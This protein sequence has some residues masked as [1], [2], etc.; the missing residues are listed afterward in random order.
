MPISGSRRRLMPRWKTL[1]AK[2]MRRSPTDAELYLWKF[3]QLRPYG[4]KWRRQAPLFGYIPDFYCAAAAMI[5]ECDGPIHE[6]QR[7]RI[8]DANLEA[9]GLLT[10]RFTNAEVLNDPFSVLRRIGLAARKRLA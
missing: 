5:V 3:L 6:A 9:K 1:A 2:Q 7:D 4:L 8:R 10:L